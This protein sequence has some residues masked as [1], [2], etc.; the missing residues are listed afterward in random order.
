MGGNS[1]LTRLASTY[2]ACVAFAVTYLLATY[3]GTSGLTA[4]IR[5]AVVAA[6]AIVFGRLL[7]GPIITSLIEAMVKDRVASEAEHT[8]DDL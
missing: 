8:E 3:F 2:F 1:D 4:A 7:V 5:G 6:L